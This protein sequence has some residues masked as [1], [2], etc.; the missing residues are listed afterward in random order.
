MK[1]VR[2]M[3]NI[4]AEELQAV[5]DA[6]GVT[7]EEGVFEER[8]S[9]IM[10]MVSTA[11][12]EGCGTDD[13]DDDENVLDEEVDVDEIYMATADATLGD[14]KVAA[15]EYVEIDEIDIENDTVTITVYDED[16]EVTAEAVDVP[17]E[18]IKAFE[19]NAEEVEIDDENE[20]I[21]AVHIKGGKKVKVSAAVEK[22]RAKLKA[23]KGNGVN[24][25]T[26][27]NGKIVKKSADQ[28]KADKKKSKVF[29]KQMK[30]F[31]KKRSKSLKKAHKL[32]SGAGEGSKKVTEGFDIVANGMTFAAEAGDVISYEDGKIT[33]VREGNTIISGLEVSESFIRNC[34]AEGVVEDEED[35]KDKVDEGK[36][37]VLSYKN[38][39][40]YVYVKEGSET[41]LG[42]RIRA[43]AFLTN[44]GYTVTSNMLDDA[45]DGKLVVL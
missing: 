16:G 33:V 3:S 24:K 18:D 43:R 37:S 39:K 19:D 1:Q 7:V 29:A 13:K 9:S 41:P 21:E 15:G 5:L 23:K 44:E 32:N 22:L 31:A 36:A 35:D 17:Y 25:F 45:A 42:N 34:I 38:G 28:L 10:E 6:K 4:V 12:E 26:I 2:K 20:V 40:G 8:V 27:Q 30:K 14:V 11:L